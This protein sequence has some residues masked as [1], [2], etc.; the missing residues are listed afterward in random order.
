MWFVG[1]YDCA[2]EE[3]IVFDV[4]LMIRKRYCNIIPENIE[5]DLYNPTRTYTD[6]QTIETI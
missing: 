5:N 2:T 3:V 4:C 6:N 1:I